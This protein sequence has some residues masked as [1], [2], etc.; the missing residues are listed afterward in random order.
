VEEV[1][2]VCP[3]KFSC[4]AYSSLEFEL[5]KDKPTQFADNLQFSRKPTKCIREDPGFDTDIQITTS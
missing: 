2:I 5:I 1:T 4:G 3:Q